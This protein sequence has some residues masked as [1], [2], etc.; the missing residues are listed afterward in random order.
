MSLNNPAGS[1]WGKWDLHV[2]TPCSIVQNYGGNTPEAW[3]SFLSDLEKLPAEFKV[4]GINDYI[5]V[6]GYE[7]VL[8]EKQENGRLKNIDLLLP[9]VELRLDKFAGVVKKGKDGYSQSDWNRINLHVIF[10][11]IDPEVIRQ[12]FLNS[13]SPKYQLIPEAEGMKGKWQGVITLASLTE[14]GKMIIEAAPDH[15]KADYSSELQEGFNNLCV[16]L[17]SVQKALENHYLENRFLL[18]VGKTEWDNMKWDDQSIAEK[19]NVI[20][21]VD[22]VFSASENPDAYAAAKKRLTESKVLDRLLDCSDAHDLSNS[23]NKDRIGNCFTWIKADPTFQGLRQ[24]VAEFDQRVYVGDVPP[25]ELLIASNRTKYASAITIKK[26]SGSSLTETWFD[27][28]IPLNHDLIAII[29]NK[30][31]GKSALADV[32]AL[33]GDTRNHGGFSFL[34]DARFRDPRNKLASHFIGTLHWHDGT[35]SEKYLNEDP[36]SSSV[37]RVKYLPQSYLENLCNELAGQGS[38]T[39]D[40]E[41]RKIIYTHVPEEEKIG[42]QSLNEL[43]DF[44]VSQ[45]EVERQQQAEA[46]YKLNAEIAAVERKQSTEF[47]KSLEL[48]NSKPKQIEDPLESESAKQETAAATTKLAVLEQTLDKVR[49]EEKIA[50]DK[51]AEAVKKS[52]H[53]TRAFQAIKNYQKNHEQFINELDAM[54]TEVDSNLK[55]QEVVSLKISTSPIEKLGVTFKN[56]TESQDEL[57]SSQDEQSLLKRRESA[58]S[59]IKKI[60]SQLGEKQRLYIVYKEQL[61][62]WERSKAALQGDKNRSN[63]IA[64]IDAEMESLISLPN[65]LYELKKTR[66]STVRKLHEQIGKVVAEYRTLYQP[67]Q[68]FVQSTARMDMPLPL[69]FDVRIAEDGF[70]DLFLERI[71]R[72]TRG[73]FA[74]VEESNAVVRMMIKETDFMNPDSVVA[75]LERIDDM[76]HRDTRDGASKA[77][78]SV[79]DQLRKDNSAEGLYNF[80]FDLQYL[81]PQYSLTYDGQEISQLSPGERGLLLL[82]F[83]LLVDKDDIPLVID[84]PEENLDNQTIYTILVKCIKTAKQR[85]QVIMVTHNPN[86]AVVCDA[87][88]IIY[89][90]CDKANMRFTYTSGAIESPS[91]KD[92]V[93]KILEGTQPAFVNRQRKYGL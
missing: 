4:L 10:D 89:A 64:W 43:L 40:G 8:K 19:R 14:L 80:L 31:S 44:K 12:Q 37:E 30:G 22:L 27:Q 56:V 76:L 68:G 28:Y 18:A 13:L 15:K 25:K 50:R 2:H 57:L 21:A 35:I 48:E 74:G 33:V 93:I 41:L 77:A 65:K 23:E 83:Y 39:F 26:K 6:D 59:E 87:E 61:V 24:A 90:E 88:Q 79:T 29:G 60:K 46:L 34:N 17:E 36:D 75:F 69:A 84:Q 1:T 16:S 70:S 71:N 53:I 7:R 82:V 49:E 91:I 54:L 32:I 66:L 67:V 20:N 55:A 47:R 3:E 92:Q 52:A 85:R 63:T 5:F 81:K 62:Q 58:E 86:L 11:Q 73:S 9:V 38:S 51:K 72:Q 42:F 45:L 78:L